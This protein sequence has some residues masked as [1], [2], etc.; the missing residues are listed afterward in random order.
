[1]EGIG[2][3]TANELYAC[4]IFDSSVLDAF[5]ALSGM[6]RLGEFQEQL[7]VESYKQFKC[8][9]TKNHH[10]DPLHGEPGS[11]ARTPFHGEPAIAAWRRPQ[12]KPMPH[13][14]R[15]FDFGK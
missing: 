15:Q 9:I 5:K 11:A 8:S 4:L 10:G 2:G 12:S 3:P 7:N 13:A 6:F 14:F 1:M